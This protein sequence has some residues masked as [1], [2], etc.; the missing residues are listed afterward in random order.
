MRVERP[1]T[2]SHVRAADAEEVGKGDNGAHVH[3]DETVLYNSD[4]PQFHFGTI[5]VSS[6]QHS[7]LVTAS[8]YA[9]WPTDAVPRLSF[10]ITLDSVADLMCPD[11]ISKMSP[12]PA[13][14]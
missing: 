9:Y 6:T 4:A 8:I 11:A 7:F 3:Q 5:E 13:S 10:N 1:Q 12:Q 2:R 14:G